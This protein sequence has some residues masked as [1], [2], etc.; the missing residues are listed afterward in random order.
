M[1]SER[2][3]RPASVK[4]CGLAR[5]DDALAAERAGAAYLGVVLSAGFGRSVEPEHAPALLEG[6]TAT[7]VAVLVDE[8]PARA[9][10]LADV[11]GASVVQLHGHESPDAVR[12][13]RAM[14]P[15]RI[16]KA[17]RVRSAEEVPAAVL[18]YGGLVDGLL[19]EGWKEGVIGGGGAVVSISPDLVRDDLPESID[20]VLAGGL[21]PE[22]VGEAVRAF[23]PDVVDV[24][25]GVESALGRK[26][27]G[28]MLRFIEAV[29]GAAAAARGR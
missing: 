11:L 4:I 24:S 28:R 1:R 2:T 22:T 21:T 8:P 3:S 15:W 29:D 16:W 18:D 25:S 26:D 9:A 14:G 5:R 27:A 23:R 6:T 19:V 13:L 12:A 7:R 10:E 20:F 17:V